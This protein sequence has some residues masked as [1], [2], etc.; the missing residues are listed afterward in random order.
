[1]TFYKQSRP[2]DGYIGYSGY[3]HADTVADAVEAY[4]RCRN[5]RTFILNDDSADLERL[6]C[7]RCGRALAE[8]AVGAEDF[9]QHHGNRIEYFPRQRAIRP[10][11]YWCAM[12]AMLHA[13]VGARSTGE[14]ARRWST[15]H[16]PA[17]IL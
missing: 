2:R 16:G 7:S 17:T 15:E 4:K 3:D 6:H 14:L 11:H 1:M 13:V 12:D 5:P 10:L 8:R 9:D